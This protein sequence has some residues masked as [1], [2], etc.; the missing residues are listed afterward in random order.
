[1]NI[2]PLIY[3]FLSL[4]LMLGVI[5]IAGMEVG[6]IDTDSNLNTF[7]DNV[8]ETNELLVG[9]NPAVPGETE[10]GYFQI[11][12]WVKTGLSIIRKTLFGFTWFL[13]STFSGNPAIVALSVGMDFLLGFAYFWLIVEFLRGFKS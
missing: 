8:T 13:R 6:T 1:M 2:K 11:L 9:I 7:S 5:Q 3:L 12:T 4:N 10:L